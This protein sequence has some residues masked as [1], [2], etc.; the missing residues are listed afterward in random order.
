V[1]IEESEGPFCRSTFIAGTTARAA[2]TPLA[3]ARQIGWFVPLW[4]KEI[5]KVSEALT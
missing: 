4:L 1:P 3:F 2:R 5:T